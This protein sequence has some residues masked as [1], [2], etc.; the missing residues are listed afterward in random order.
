MLLL[1]IIPCCLPANGSS[2]FRLGFIPLL[3]PSPPL[4]PMLRLSSSSVVPDEESFEVL[5]LTGTFPQPQPTRN[6]GAG[7]SFQASQQ[8]QQRSSFSGIVGARS[9]SFISSSSSFLDEETP[10]FPSSSSP[11]PPPPS[12][13]SSLARE[14]L[15]KS[16]AASLSSL[17]WRSL[18]LEQVAVWAFALLAWNV[19]RYLISHD[20]SIRTKLP[21]F[22]VTAAG[23]VILDPELNRPLVDP[24]TINDSLLIWTSIGL[25]IALIV[26]LSSSWSHL[27]TMPGSKSILL[28]RHLLHAG[29]CGFVLT[30]GLS[31]GAT[32]LFKYYVQR[33]RPNFYAL[34]EFD[35]LSKMCAS[36]SPRRIRDAH[37][38]FPSGHS[39]LVSCGMTFLALFL[40]GRAVATLIVTTQRYGRPPSV[41]QRMLALVVCVLLPL[42]WAIF[43]G[44]SR[45]VDGWHH[46]SDVLAGWCL[47]G[48]CAILAYHTYFPPMWVSLPHYPWALWGTTAIQSSYSPSNNNITNTGT[49]YQVTDSRPLPPPPPSSANKLPSF[50]E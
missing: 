39:S 24:P 20:V 16:T 1:L 38:S 11:I 47:G 48:L 25:P 32:L 34:C 14:A 8:Q 30:I 12:S 10:P 28:R 18:L 37:F 42:G 31:E 17:S 33:R 21:P 36:S 22:Q 40:M 13:G 43:V 26:V 29:V 3:P 41:A 27:G 46:P 44:T 9:S 23:D 49:S 45:I 2:S 5:P 19:P 7:A 15:P 6:R 4:S 35:K 50:V